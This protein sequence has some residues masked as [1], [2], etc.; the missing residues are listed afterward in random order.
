MPKQIIAL[1]EHNLPTDIAAKAGPSFPP[2]TAD[3]L[4]DFGDGRIAVMDEAGI[5]LQVLSLVAYGV[6]NLP[7]A[8]SVEFAREANDRM[9]AACVAHPARFRAFAA[10]PMSDPSAA[11]DELRRCVTEHGFLGAMVFGHTGGRW[12]D[13]PTNEPVFSALERLNVPLY[14]HPA[15]PLPEVRQA[16]YSDLGDAGQSLSTGGWGWHVECGMHLLRLVVTG[17]FDRHPGLRV[18]V[19]HMGE[20]LP[21]SLARADDRLSPVTRGERGV[22]ETILAQVWITTSA[23]IT[24][25]PLLCA[26]QVFGADRIMFSV[27]HPFADSSKATAALRA[28]PIS[29]GDLEK[30]AWANATAFL[31]L[32]G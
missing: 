8:Q 10:L 20:N 14:I 30:V 17:T 24:F 5:D 3:Q 31:G 23:Y 12:L 19:G 4:N 13:H 18:V 9:A 7:P 21:F 28:A 1:E 29:P 15:P 11:A 6:Q 25:P 26:L 27:D 22:A 16:Y 2:P 32:A